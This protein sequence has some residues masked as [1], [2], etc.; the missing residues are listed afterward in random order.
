MNDKKLLIGVLG[1][2]VCLLGLLT[3]ALLPVLSG[4]SALDYDDFFPGIVVSALG[5]GGFLGWIVMACGTPSR[6]WVLP[7]GLVAAW[8]ALV[9]AASA[10]SC[11]AQLSA[12]EGFLRSAEERAER[13]R[14]DN[15]AD[16][17]GDPLSQ[18]TVRDERDRAQADV[19]R[20]QETVR[21]KKSGRLAGLVFLVVGVAAGVIFVSLKRRKPA[22]QTSVA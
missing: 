2:T 22:L 9:G 4:G 5:A 3:S 8:G 16:E 21:R 20:L 15:V 14:G 18:Q 17:K 6:N 11:H 1:S 10:L 13:Y 7:M 12:N 19:A